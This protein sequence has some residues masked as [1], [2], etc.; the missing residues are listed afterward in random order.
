VGGKMPISN[1]RE[2]K[3]YFMGSTN[4][5][6]LGQIKVKSRNNPDFWKSMISVTGGHF[7]YSLRMQKKPYFTSLRTTK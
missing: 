2:E 4:F 3:T 7:D 6:L 5:K 1:Y